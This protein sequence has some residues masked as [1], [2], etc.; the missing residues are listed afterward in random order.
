MCVLF[1]SRKESTFGRFIARS[2]CKLNVVARDKDEYIKQQSVC[3]YVSMRMAA[4]KRGNLHELA[5]PEAE[6]ELA[7]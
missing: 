7:G 4:G 6:A 1:I 5:Q 2:E 3:V